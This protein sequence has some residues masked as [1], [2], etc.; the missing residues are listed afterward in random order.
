MAGRVVWTTSS[1]CLWLGEHQTRPRAAMRQVLTGLRLLAEDAGRASP[2]SP[3]DT[4]RSGLRA[5]EPPWTE[6]LLASEPMDA[7]L[8]VKKRWV[9]AN[10]STL[11][12]CSVSDGLA[13]TRRAE[14]EVL[15]MI[16]AV[17]SSPTAPDLSAL[18]AAGSIVGEDLVLLRQEG[19][20]APVLCSAMV[21]FSFG[22][23]KSKLGQ[24]LDAIH[25]PVPGFRRSL[26]K[27]LDRV[28]AKIAPDRGFSRH[29]VEFRWNDDLLHPSIT[30]SSEAKGRLEPSG[31]RSAPEHMVARIEYQTLRR[32]PVSKHILFTIATL[33]D[34]V[35]TL[36]SRS[37]AAAEALLARVA[38]FSESMCAYKGL[39]PRLRDD[40]L[41]YLRAAVEKVS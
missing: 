3:N 35:A 12:K 24:P 19:D 16:S 23:L 2:Y 11:A 9:F 5:L 39:T 15:D 10:A 7:A 22:Q 33:N 18:E 30:A 17:R 41:V 8:S 14:A 29:N 26:S 37:P 13:S 40:L 4:L 36:V 31:A 27:P 28:F 32:L 1:I 25:E 34:P 21:C 6:W 38:S 20:E